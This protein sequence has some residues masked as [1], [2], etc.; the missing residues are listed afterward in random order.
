MNPEQI[1]QNNLN[2]LNAQNAFKVTLQELSAHYMQMEEWEKP[3]ASK[4]IGDFV[5]KYC[6]EKQYSIA[7]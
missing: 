6:P 4:R 2:I 7:S 5:E 3:E 1:Y